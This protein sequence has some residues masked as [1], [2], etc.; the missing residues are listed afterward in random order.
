MLFSKYGNVSGM[1]LGKGLGCAMAL[2]VD[3][4]RRL[5]AGT[6]TSPYGICGGKSGTGTGFSPSSVSII[7]RVLHTHISLL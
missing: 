3:C 1:S 2:T 5:G 4:R 7:P 6:Q